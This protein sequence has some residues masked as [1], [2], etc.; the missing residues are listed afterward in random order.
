MQSMSKVQGRTSSPKVPRRPKAQY[1]D[2]S[3]LLSI[4]IEAFI[5]PQSTDTYDESAIRDAIEKGDPDLLFALGLQF[6]IVGVVGENYGSCKVNGHPRLIKELAIEC[7]LKLRNQQNAK[8]A[9]DDLTFKRL[10]RFFRYHIRDY[11]KSTGKTSFLYKKYGDKTMRPELI[12]PGS[13]YMVEPEDADDLIRAYGNLDLARGT[14]FAERIGRIVQVRIP[15]PGFQS[16][17]ISERE[18]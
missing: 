15:N 17:A 6:A 8:L 16:L 5:E 3:S 2:E 14:Q 1:L 10:A 12:F 18:E 9:P 4:K 7:G 13:E 11:I